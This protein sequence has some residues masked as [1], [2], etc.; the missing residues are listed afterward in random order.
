MHI[1]VS[2]KVSNTKRGK[3]SYSVTPNQFNHLQIGSQVIVNFNN[4]LK[5]AIVIDKSID[6]NFEFKLKPIVCIHKKNPLNIYQDKLCNYINTNTIN[7]YIDIQNLF[8]PLI[9]D[10]EISIDYYKDDQY[11]GE[12]K[13]LKNDPKLNEY[14]SV[15]KFKYNEKIKL[16]TYVDINPTYD[17][18]VTTKQLIAYNY[19]KEHGQTSVSKLI[20]IT[21]ISRAVINTMIKNGSLVKQEKPRQFEDYF[22]M[23]WHGVNTLSVEQELAFKSIKSG[24]N[25]LYGVSSSGKTEVYLELIKKQVLEGK[26]VLVLV[27]SVLLA[28]QVVGRIQKQINDVIIYHNQLSNGQKAS[29]RSQIESGEKKVIIST[30]NGV[31]L[32][33]KNLS[34]VIFDEAHSSN[35]KLNKKV[36]ASKNLIIDGLLAQNID[37]L[38][39]SATPSINDFARSQL[40]DTNLI[41]LNNRFGES[42]FPQ[43]EFVQA[44]DKLIS[45]ELNSLITRNK[46]RNK[47]TMIFF[48]KVGYSRQV[49]CKECY[50]LHLCPICNKPLTYVKNKK[51]LVCMYDGYKQHFNN[52]C[53]KCKSSNLTLIGVGIEQF[54]EKL[55][56][57]YPDLNI[58]I[59]DNNLKENQMYELMNEFGSGKIDILV[60]TQVIAYGIDFLNVD[61]IYIKNVD[62]LLNLNEVNS[63]EKTYS[64]LEQVAGRVGRGSK[65]SNAIIETNHREHFV[66]KA[67]ENHSYYDFYKQELALRKAS[68]NPPYFRICKI[69]ISSQN[70]KKL[71]VIGNKFR[72]NLLNDFQ[73]VSPITTPYINIKM[74][75]HRRY[76]LIKYRHEDIC[77]IIKKNLHLL[78]SNQIE[79]YVDL[80]NVEIGV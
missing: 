80:N 33:F 58:K 68:N 65:F 15:C 31:F 44:T 74:S 39:G 19:L 8:S 3:F 24:L 64:L 66:F 26:Q 70:E 59:L 62:N 77:E 27:P 38:L 54:Y 6:T 22:D 9:S 35:Y 75:M 55:K 48:N 69:E 57:T 46:L 42:N 20:K 61:S 13:K 14:K 76:I 12:F 63:H 78:T 32:P 51:Q 30:F 40:S 25:L 1:T 11:I 52:Q 5:L 34:T 49:L 41:T 21:N 18:G 53:N 29:Y 4:R 23:N 16:Y 2:L 47:P 10:C 17:E 50:H 37:I 36:H 28:I 60:G 45:T 7:D 67:I 43:I 79:F 72:I 73:S 56:A 71:E